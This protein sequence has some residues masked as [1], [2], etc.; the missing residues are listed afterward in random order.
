VGAV[1][2]CAVCAV[3]AAAATFLYMVSSCSWHFLSASFAM[4]SLVSFFHCHAVIFSSSLI[5]SSN[6]TLFFLSHA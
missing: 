5:S 3:A 1:V 4:H 2:V 6:V